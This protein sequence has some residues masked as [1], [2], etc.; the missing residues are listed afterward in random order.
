MIRK[1]DVQWW[2]LEA[3]KNPAAAPTLIEELAE[4][5]VELDAANERLREEVIQLQRRAPVTVA[6]SQDDAE[7]RALRRKI[8][9]LQSLVD[10]QTS[11]EPALVLLTDQLQALRL[12]PPLARQM[13]REGRLVLGRQSHARFQSLLLAR[14]HEELVLL[15]S[16]R[17]GVKVLTSSIPLMVDSGAPELGEG[18][19]LKQNERLTAAVAVQKPPRFWTLV[20]RRGYA[21]QFI[22]VGLERELAHGR[23]FF[24]SPFERDTPAALIDGDRGDLLAVTRWGKAVRFAQRIILGSG[25]TAIDL[26]NDDQV[27]GALPLAANAEIVIVT[28]SGYGMRRDTA[29][30]DAQS[31]PGGGGKALMQAYDV[32]GAFPYDPEGQVLFL[33]Y[34]GKLSLIEMQDVPLHNR[35]SK[36]T[37]IRDFDRDPAVAAIALPGSV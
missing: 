27:V 17:R 19:A 26:E 25:S 36:G 31:K 29:Q 6:P 33:T 7:V 24:D 5:L 12:P 30:L 10:G 4:R 11:T 32:L 14:P 2:V 20:T 13:A 22:H 28:G 3:R 23:P 1:G 16:Q 21:Q 18:P 8:A 37:Q 35:A 34:S 9:T 15:T